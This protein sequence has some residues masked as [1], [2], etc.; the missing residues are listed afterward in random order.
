MYD[1]LI[2]S[3][4]LNNEKSNQY[5]LS[6]QISLDG[7]S[8]SVCD[9]ISNKFIYLTHKPFTKNT[10]IVEQTNDILNSDT[11][12]N[13]KYKNVYIA[14]DLK[15][16]TL[17]PKVLFDETQKELYYSKNYKIEANNKVYYDTIKLYDSV[18]LY[19]VDEALELSLKTHFGNPKISHINS[20][21]TQLITAH[22]ETKH[23]V[24]LTMRDTKFSIIVLIN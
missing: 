7:F 21:K 17:I 20:V 18:N 2:S 23:T 3:P 1:I 5:I 4:A 11:L 10:T 9:S 22:P 16:S 8:F 13:L 12:L 15:P 24:Y 19:T 14:L 6:I